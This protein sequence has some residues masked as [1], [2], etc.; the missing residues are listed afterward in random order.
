[1][2]LSVVAVVL[3]GAAAYNQL[4]DA[5]LAFVATALVVGLFVL[6]SSECLSLLNAF[7]SIGIALAWFLFLVLIAACGWRMNMFKRPGFAWSRLPPY[8]TMF[9]LPVAVIALAVLIT[10]VVAP[11]SNWDSMTYHMARVEHWLQNGT[12]AH[13]PT[14]IDR[15]LY[16]QPW[17]EMAIAHMQALSGNDYFAGLIQGGAF[18]GC[19]VVVSLIARA[20]GLSAFGQATAVVMMATVPMA[21]IQGSSTQNDL[22]AAFWGV[23]GAYGTVRIVQSGWSGKLGRLRLAGTAAALGLALAT[24]GTAYF[25]SVPLILWIGS[26]LLYRY[27]AKALMA[28]IGM[29]CIILA[30]NTGTLVRNHQSFGS[31]TGP[32]T[33][34]LVNQAV[35]PILLLSNVTRNLH[36]HLTPPVFLESRFRL[37]ERIDRTVRNIHAILDVDISDQRTTAWS[38]GTYGFGIWQFEEDN[39]SAPLHLL[40]VCMCLVLY[41]LFAR[42]IKP[43]L[44]GGYVLC[45]VG[46]FLLFCLILKVQ[47]WHNRLHLFLFALMTPFIAC[48]LHNLFPSWVIAIGL[49]LFLLSAFEPTFSNFNRPWLLGE[50]SIWS[51]SRWQQ[52]FVKR[53]ALAAP[54]MNVFIPLQSSGC[55][56][57][58]LRIGS[59][60]WEYP[61]W[62]RARDLNLRMTFTHLVAPTAQWF[63]NS[64]LC[65]LIMDVTTETQFNLENTDFVLVWEESPLRLFLREG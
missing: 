11:P 49:C 65:A 61:L 36:T 26:S 31:I 35:S 25:Y 50:R 6:A 64:D 30:L 19:L 34:S 21:I 60:S 8:A 7:T 17:A 63:P 52:R 56:Q 40:L 10:G 4:R 57:V 12:V 32:A 13:Y 42:R 53:P 23:L 45:L 27:R 15:Q 43:G 1:V 20:F 16:Q 28:G 58:A 59:D 41:V 2:L 54:Y 46:A 22:V 51:Q 9:M 38:V 14:S 55:E 44:I 33:T 29:G 24:K 3:V 5:R 39:T 48:I 18:V 62:V 37:V 47:P